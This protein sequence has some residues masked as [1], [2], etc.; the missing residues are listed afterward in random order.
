[1]GK[2]CVVLCQ[3]AGCEHDHAILTQAMNINHKQTLCINTASYK[4]SNYSYFAPISSQLYI[5]LAEINSDK[6]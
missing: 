3:A 2:M 1:M 4:T 6:L 5:N